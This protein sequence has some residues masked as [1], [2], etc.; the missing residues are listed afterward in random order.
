MM[1]ITAQHY[2]TQL[3]CV[4]ASYLL[5][6]CNLTTLLQGGLGKAVALHLKCLHA[7]S[8]MRLHSFNVLSP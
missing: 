6:F 7:T 3:A 2:E 1:V 4:K 5:H 8:K